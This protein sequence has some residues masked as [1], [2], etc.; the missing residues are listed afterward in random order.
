M[1]EPIRP[2]GANEQ[3]KLSTSLSIVGMIVAILRERF[4]E[5]SWSDPTLPW[6]W[7]EDVNSTEIFIESGWNKNIE[8]RTVRPGIWVDRDQNVYIKSGIGHQDQ[9]SVNVRHGIYRYHAFGEV[10][11]LLDCTA[12]HRG[13]SMLLGSVVQDFFQMTA[14]AIMEYFYLRSMSD[15]IL[16]RTVPFDKDDKIWS[17]QVQFRAQYETRWA[18]AEAAPMFNNF[19]MRLNNVDNPEEYF[20]EIASRAVYEP[21][22]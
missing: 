6:K 7:L 14:P 10:D 4:T 9:M 21:S 18:S 1:T 8:A 15:V 19:L 16:N 20:R 11:I 5:S 3:L 17:S 22:T 13:E 12:P 2:E